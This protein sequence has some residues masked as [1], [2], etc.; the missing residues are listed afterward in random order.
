MRSSIESAGAPRWFGKY[1]VLRHLANGGMAEIYLARTTGIEGFEKLMVVKRML[2]A[3]A[4][5]P[6]SVRLFLN[7]ARLAARLQHANVVQVHDVGCEDGDYFI[8]MEYV[9][10]VDVRRLQARSR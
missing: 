1:E 5:E 7:E 2:P 6:D 10:G 4:A 8:A 3:L 9:H